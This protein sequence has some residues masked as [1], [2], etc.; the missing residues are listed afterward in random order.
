MKVKYLINITT[1][2]LVLCE[3]TKRWWSWKYTCDQKLLPGYSVCQ[4]ALNL[5]P[6]FSVNWGISPSQSHILTHWSSARPKSE[7]IQ[8]RYDYHNRFR[9]NPFLKSKYFCSFA[10]CQGSARNVFS[11]RVFDNTITP[12]PCHPL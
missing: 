10:F 8:F 11:W 12:I 9:Q 5:F 6:P 7:H 3:N 1:L 4:P 2:Y